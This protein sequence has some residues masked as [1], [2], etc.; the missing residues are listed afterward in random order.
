VS[1]FAD[2]RL[3]LAAVCWAVATA[4]AARWVARPRRALALRVRPYAQLS[5]SRLGAG[6]DHASALGVAAPTGGAVSEILGPMLR[7][8]A[9]VL[10]G[11]VDAGATESI[12]LR[13]RQAG[14]VD[15]AADQYRMRQLGFTIGGLTLGIALG[16]SRGFSAALVLASGA[17]LAFPAA[18]FQRNRVDRAI[19]ERRSLMRVELY[20]VTQL[21]AV[22]LRAGSSAV[23]AVRNVTVRGQGPVVEELREALGWI[24]A[25]MRPNDAY[26]RLTEITPEPSAARLYRALGSSVSS[27]GDIARSLLAMSTDLRAARREEVERTAVRRRVAMLLPLLGL[28]AP[29]MLL[30]VVAAL[31]HIVLGGLTP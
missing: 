16:L 29:V 20:T 9:E 17:L 25:G 1:T 11:I 31:P 23:D 28:I 22:Y 26:A 24:G 7:R 3:L 6:V 4:T 13:L 8:G 12:E 30:F 21:V 14:F 15:V 5:R 10:A 27:G 2:P 18:T 19:E